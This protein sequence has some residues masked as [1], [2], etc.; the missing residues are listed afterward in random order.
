MRRAVVS[1]VIAVAA[2]SCTTTGGS[3]T[4]TSAATTAG[5]Q[6]STTTTTTGG[7]DEATTSTTSPTTT[8]T[9]PPIPEDELPLPA[10]PAQ[11]EGPYYPV[12]KLDDR[13]NDLTVVADIGGTPAGNVLILEG[14]LVTT[15]GV[16]VEGGVIEIWQVDS[17]GI[18]LHPDDPKTADRDPNFQF[19]GEAV[20]AADGSWSFRTIDPGYYEPRPRHLHVKVRLDGDEVLT[21]QIYFSNDP[22]AAGLDELLVASIGEETDAA[23][24]TVLVARHRIVLE[25]A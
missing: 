11:Q 3:E 13:D 23:G 8:D 6:D 4:T 5:Q 12:E 22:D 25:A 21:T 16:P 24:A 17:A 10:T 19:Y 20:A 15:D 18:Y 9:L 2:A 14:R 1:L 7:N